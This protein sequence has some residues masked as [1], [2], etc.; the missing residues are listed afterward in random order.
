MQR[1]KRHFELFIGVFQLLSKTLY[2]LCQALQVGMFLDE[3]DWHFI[4]DILSLSY[5]VMLLVHLI[6][7]PNENM[8]HILRYLGFGLSWV[9]KVKDQWKSG[10][11]EAMVAIA[12][13]GFAAMRYT[14]PHFQ[15][16]RPK[17]HMQHAQQGLA[18]AGVG[19]LLFLVLEWFRFD[20]QTRLNRVVHALVAG[21]VNL[22]SGFAIYHLWQTVPI[23]KFKDDDVIPSYSDY[24]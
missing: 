4:S 14:A 2:N 13:L 20:D 17:I 23:R 6:S 9:A 8:N 15:H 10:F 18:G 11:W 3:G 12:F 22:A 5:L 24:F 19:F 1:N 21:A 16:S 7:M